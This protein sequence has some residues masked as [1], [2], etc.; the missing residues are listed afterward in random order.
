MQE[1]ISAK[2]L[3]QMHQAK[4]ELVVPHKLHSRYPQVSGYNLLDIKG[5]ISTVRKTLA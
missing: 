5:F 2:Q 1:G 3:Q 4:V